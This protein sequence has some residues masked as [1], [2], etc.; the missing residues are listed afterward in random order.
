MNDKLLAL[1]VCLGPHC[2]GCDPVV[3]RMGGLHE[4]GNGEDESKGGTVFAE[5]ELD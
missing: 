4:R 1:H 3:N 5:S 2:L